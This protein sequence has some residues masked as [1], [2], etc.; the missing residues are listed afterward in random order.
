MIYFNK[1]L[2]HS[3]IS[4]CKY[5]RMNVAHMLTQSSLTQCLFSL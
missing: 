4:L 5:E 3:Y 2:D 1:H